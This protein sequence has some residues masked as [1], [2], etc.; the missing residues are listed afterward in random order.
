VHPRIVTLLITGFA[1]TACFKAPMELKTAITRQ[2]EEIT[3]I[4]QAY[5]TN[6]TALL[7]ALEKSQLD[8]LQQAEDNLRAKYLHEGKITEPAG[9]NADANLLVIRLTTEN[10]ILAF[11]DS[12]RTLVHDSFEKKR[13][14]FLK[15][16]TNIDNIAQINRAMSEYV[17]SLLRL[18]KAQDAFGQALLSRVNTLDKSLPIIS[19]IVDETV[20]V[21]GEEVDK[22]VPNEA[23]I[24]PAAAEPLAQAQI[25][26]TQKP[27]SDAQKPSGGVSK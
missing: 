2:A 1:C 15:L 13:V 18:R 9:T 19:Q 24:K 6:I 21:T 17:D 7:N 14:E 3:K 27:G 4:N 23:N 11:F 8:Y 12:K 22:F 20:R 16:Q 26:V 25:S 5:Q 10:K